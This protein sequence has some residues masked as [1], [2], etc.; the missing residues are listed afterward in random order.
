M[1]SDP[2]VSGPHPDGVHPESAAG[3][4]GY[5][6]QGDGELPGQPPGP[7]HRDVTHD[8]P[9]PLREE[10][11]PGLA[12]E[13]AMRATTAAVAH[14]QSDAPRHDATPGDGEHGGSVADERDQSDGA[15]QGRYALAQGRQAERAEESEKVA[16]ESVQEDIGSAQVRQ[17]VA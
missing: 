11:I 17:F 16:R 5:L 7:R 14:R 15:A 13:T 10:I 2:Y 3:E 8:P 12:D 1:V 6:H 9:E 4:E